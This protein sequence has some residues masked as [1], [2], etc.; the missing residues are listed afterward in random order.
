MATLPVKSTVPVE[1]DKMPF[2]PVPPFAPSILT[3]P[4]TLSIPA[5]TSRLFVIPL[6]PGAFIVTFP[7]TDKVIPELIW[8]LVLLLP[9]A[10]VI[11]LAELLSETV[12]VAPTAIITSSVASGIFPPTQVPPSFQ[13]PPGPV[14]VIV[15]SV[16]SVH[17]FSPEDCPIAVALNNFPKQ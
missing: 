3:F 13:L 11:D 9:P 14:D 8:S 6:A 12:T 1:I 17:T 16:N 2:L 15:G 10:R 5:P 4:T 7:E